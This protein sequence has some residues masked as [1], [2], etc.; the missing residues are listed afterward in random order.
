[1]FTRGRKRK[2][3]R[4]RERESRRVCGTRVRRR[5]TGSE[6]D[7]ERRLANE[8]E[9]GSTVGGTGGGRIRLAREKEGCSR[10]DSD[11]DIVEAHAHMRASR[12]HTR[13]RRRM[14][15]EPSSA[16]QTARLPP[17]TFGKINRIQEKPMVRQASGALSSSTLVFPL[18]LSLTR[19]RSR[20]FSFT[21]SLSIS[22]PSARRPPCFSPRLSRA[23]AVSVF[24]AS[25]DEERERLACT[26]WR[27]TEIAAMRAR[28]TAKDGDKD[29]GSVRGARGRGGRRGLVCESIR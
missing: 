1:M 3:S 16:L 20:S 18:F 15:T 11:G 19:L 22:L 28:T 12:A 9:G 29:E 10:R 2:G 7:E 27:S 24:V 5:R 6:L 14:H 17:R 25:S 23:H 8:R 13:A 21:L 4:G 26:H